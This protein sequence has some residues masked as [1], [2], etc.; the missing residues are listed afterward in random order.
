MPNDVQTGIQ[1]RDV[2]SSPVKTVTEQDSVETAAKLMKTNNLGSIIVT[3]SHGNPVGIITEKDIINRVVAEN[4]LPRNINAQQAMSYP[5]LSIS[6]HND[7]KQA[8]E[9]MRTRDVR[10]LVVMD[11]NRMIGLIASN[12]IVAI[13]PA[14]IEIISEKTKITHNLPVTLRRYQSTGYCDNCRQWFETL[15][16]VDGDFLC[17]ECHHEIHSE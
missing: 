6:P 8:A 1:V 16:D 13:T 10:R 11:R 12:D 17:E 15:Q 14:L 3:D 5:V 2:M 4:L 7:I 9:T